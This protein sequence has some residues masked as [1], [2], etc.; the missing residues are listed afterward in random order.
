L[1]ENA[2]PPRLAAFFYGTGPL[3]ECVAA[4]EIGRRTL[5]IHR[6]WAHNFVIANSGVAK[7]SVAES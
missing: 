3:P 5:S 2:G 7:A 4:F 6:T 1:L